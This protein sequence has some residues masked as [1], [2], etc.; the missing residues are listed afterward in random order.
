MNCWVDS[1][2]VPLDPEE[3]QGKDPKESNKPKAKVK[4]NS[5]K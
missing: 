1:V 2:G 5:R 3:S 4:K